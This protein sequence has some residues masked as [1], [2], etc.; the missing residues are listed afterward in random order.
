MKTLLSVFI[1]GVVAIGGFALLQAYQGREK[2]E[3]SAQL[4]GGDR[5]EE[6]CLTAAGYSYDSAVGAC[7]RE[8]EMT[9][10]TTE[11]AKTA[12]EQ[13]GE[14]YALTL[15]SITVLDAED[16]YDLLFERGENRTQEAVFIREG[17]IV[18]DPSQDAE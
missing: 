9:P 7:V 11:V 17:E 8:W 2:Q 1:I 13:I 6:G 15:V 14:G 5:T 10:E 16:S 4:I 3:D 12:V 18:S